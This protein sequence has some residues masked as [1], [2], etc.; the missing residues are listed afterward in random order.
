MVIGSIIQITW[1][2]RNLEENKKLQIAQGD[3][4]LQKDDYD[5][6]HTTAFGECIVTLFQN[7]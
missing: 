5:T 4:C 1:K 6:V 3:R 2:I 7:I